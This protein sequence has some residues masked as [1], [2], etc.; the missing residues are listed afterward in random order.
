MNGWLCLCMSVWN[1]RKKVVAKG[2]KG[3][4]KSKG[5]RGKKEKRVWVER[6]EKRKDFVSERVRQQC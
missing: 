6:G 5:R 4:R 3:R 2:S 1:E